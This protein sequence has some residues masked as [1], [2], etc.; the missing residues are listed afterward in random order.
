MNTCTGHTNP[1]TCIAPSKALRH[2][3]HSFTCNKHHTEKVGYDEKFVRLLES[4]YNGTMSTVWVGGGL[5]EWFA[6]IIGVMQGCILSP[7]LFNTLLEVVMDVP[8]DRWEFGIKGSGT[9]LSNLRFANDINL[10]ANSEGELQQLVDRV[11]VTSSRFGLVISDFKTEAQCIGRD[12]QILNI[13]LGAS[14]LKQTEHFVYLG[15]TVSADQSCVKDIEHRIG[16]AAGIVRKLGKIWTAK[17]ISKV[18]KVTLYKTISPVGSVVQ[19]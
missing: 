3:S 11:H 16:L 12:S 18:T 6:M 9:C 17:D 4:L 14:S 13:K 15:G 19:R 2:G 7:L 5:T 1:S 10:L 8:L